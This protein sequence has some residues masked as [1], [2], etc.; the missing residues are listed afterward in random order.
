[1]KNMFARF[2]T[3]CARFSGQPA[4]QVICLALSLLGIAAY[5]SDNDHFVNG[6][7]LV[8]S[9]ITLMLLPLLQ[10]S[11]NRDGAAM[12]AKLDELIK[13]NTEARDAL[14]GLENRSEEEIEQMRREGEGKRQ[15]D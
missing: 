4:M 5:V 7:N 6:A 2:S 9:V 13:V 10:A 1:M 15:C 3:G 12:Q 14:I 8:I 11:Q